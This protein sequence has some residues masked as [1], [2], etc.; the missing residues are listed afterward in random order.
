MTRDEALHVNSILLK[1]EA[2]ETLLDELLSIETLQEIKMY[3][4]TLEND[5]VGKAVFN[6][7]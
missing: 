5:L 3:D 1:I 7:D 2:Y 4:T 6:L